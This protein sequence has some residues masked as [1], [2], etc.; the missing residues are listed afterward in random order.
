LNNHAGTSSL[1]GQ[2]RIDIAGGFNIIINLTQ[3]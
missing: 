3:I 2:F 1:P